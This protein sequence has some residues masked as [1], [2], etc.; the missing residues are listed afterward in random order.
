ME[1]I[2]NLPT[3]ILAHEIFPFFNTADLG[4]LDTAVRAQISLRRLIFEVYPFL[5][6][7]LEVAGGI[8]SFHVKWYCDRSIPCECLIF[9][10]CASSGEILSVVDILYLGCVRLQGMC[11]CN[12]CNAVLIFIIILHVMKNSLT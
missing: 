2:L 9:S 12:L 6:L 8:R 3:D 5:N 10:E 7:N 4:R 11:P 1:G